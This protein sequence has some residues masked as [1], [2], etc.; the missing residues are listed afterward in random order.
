MRRVLDI[1]GVAVELWADDPAL[2]RALGDAA[3]GFETTEA[4]AQVSFRVG[5]T[6]HAVPRRPPDDEHYG[7]R[8]W[9]RP[10]GA[11]IV[12]GEG[13][14]VLIEGGRAN[15]WLRTLDDGP[16]FEPLASLALCWL[17]A[18]HD[19]FL[20]HAAVVGGGGDA[21][22]ALGHSGAGK[23]TLSLAALAAG[24][25]TLSDDVAVI[26]PD[27]GGM[28]VH[29]VHQAPCVPRDL[30]G[31][32]LD[33][34][35]RLYDARDRAQLDCGVLTAGARRIVGTVLVGHSERAGGDL[36]RLPGHAAMPLLLQSFAALDDP[37]H[38]AA[39]L[40]V[41]G[42]LARLPVWQ[43]G[44]GTNAASRRLTSG[45]HL[46]R[47]LQESRDLSAVER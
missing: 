32:V 29:G 45:H 9:R 8:L 26:Q 37:V 14:G 27:P 6:P 25:E 42:R 12:A 35:R 46:D 4:D 40:A 20:V 22:I 7:R 5:A 38:R 39:Y 18:R 1:A 17:L 2:G 19:R 44:H 47:C 33:G 15:G 11:L 21:V 16:Q 43:L 3:A 24:M 10:S 28:L 34:A 23:S 31:V 13:V 30:G 41:A 36:R